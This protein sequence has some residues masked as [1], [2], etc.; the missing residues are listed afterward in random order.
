MKKYIYLSNIIIDNL[1]MR[2]SASVKSNGQRMRWPLEE[3]NSKAQPSSTM[4]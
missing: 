2:H 4:M 1:I 3:P